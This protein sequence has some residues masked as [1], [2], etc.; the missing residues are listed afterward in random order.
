MSYIPTLAQLTVLCALLGG[1]STIV[2]NRKTPQQISLEGVVGHLLAASSI[3]PSLFLLG[4]AFNPSLAAQL[5]ELGLYLAAAAVAL[6]YIAVARQAKLGVSCGVEV[7][8]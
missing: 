5:E 8:A 4:C 3:P 7:P 6:L 2:R 1:A